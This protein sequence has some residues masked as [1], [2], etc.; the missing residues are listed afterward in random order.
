M[1]RFHF[2]S[3]SLLGY[4]FI[5]SPTITN[6]RGS[7]KTNKWDLGHSFYLPK[8]TESIDH[9]FYREFRGYTLESMLR[10]STTLRLLHISIAER[11]EAESGGIKLLVLIIRNLCERHPTR[12][13]RYL[14]FHVFH[15]NR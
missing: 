3:P 2:K 15:T 7:I 11:Q 8:G 10:N 12:T 1:G 13:E 9:I 6:I 4:A 5:P 14:F